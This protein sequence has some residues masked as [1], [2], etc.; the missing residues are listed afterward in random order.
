MK[1]QQKK[2]KKK[3]NRFPGFLHPQETGHNRI[4]SS[5]GRPF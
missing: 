5:A 2:K 3:K 1:Q 4:S